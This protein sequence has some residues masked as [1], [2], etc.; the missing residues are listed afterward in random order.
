MTPSEDRPEVTVFAFGGRF[1]RRVA[2]ALGL[3]EI[4]DRHAPFSA[5][6]ESYFRYCIWC[7]ETDDAGWSWVY[8]DHRVE[9]GRWVSRV[10]YRREAAPSP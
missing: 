8:T 6:P 1:P 4:K 9:Y 5:S 3:H 7:G 10:R 2:C